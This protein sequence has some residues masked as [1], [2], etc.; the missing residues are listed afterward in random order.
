M[1]SRFLLLV[2]AA[3]APAV[4]TPAEVTEENLLASLRDDHPA[5]AAATAV[6]EEA[7]AE[8][9][10]ARLLPNPSLDYGAERPSGATNPSSD[11]DRLK[12]T[13]PDISLQLPSERS[14]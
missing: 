2:L 11:I 3:A 7:R 13:F 14:R 4:A 5:L 6:E 12:N 9:L 10:R 8:S 1:G